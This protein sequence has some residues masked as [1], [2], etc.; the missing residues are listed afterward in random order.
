MHVVSICEKEDRLLEFLNL[1]VHFVGLDMGLELGEVVDSTFTVSGC[2]DIC[3]VLPD[4]SGNLA[5]G[6]LDG[7]DGVGE[8]TVL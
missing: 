2:N 8:S 4:V 5:P 6:C 3:G 7:C 1:V